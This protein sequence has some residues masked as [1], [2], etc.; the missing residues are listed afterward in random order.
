MISLYESHENLYN[1]KH[2]F[3]TN[4]HARQESLKK[5]ALEINDKFNENYSPDDIAKKIFHLRS[6][7]S[8]EKNKIS[9]SSRSGAGTDELYKPSVWWFEE[10]S[11]LALLK[12]D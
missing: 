1:C 6:Q 9:T 2:K 10:I 3:Y 4:K 8:K 5:I 12:I 11:F 7:F